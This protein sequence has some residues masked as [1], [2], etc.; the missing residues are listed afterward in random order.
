M[1]DIEAVKGNRQ[2]RNS[3]GGRG[4]EVRKGKKRITQK[5]F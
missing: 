4:K 3:E 1:E 2:R 5:F